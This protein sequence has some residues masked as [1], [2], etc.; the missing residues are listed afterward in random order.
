MATANITQGF[1]AVTPKRDCPHCTEDNIAPKDAFENVN[2]ED[3]CSDCEHKGENWLCL[4]PSCKT[5]RCSRYVKS[6]MVAHNSANSE[7]PICFSFADFSFWCYSCDSYVVHPLL[8]HTEAFYLQK[9]GELSDRE[10]LQQIRDSKHQEQIREEDEDEDENSGAAV[11][12]SA[13]TGEAEEE[14]KNDPVDSLTAAVADLSLEP[15]K[16]FTYQNLVDGLKTNKFKNIMVMTGAGVSVS[17]GIP[18]FRS[19]GTG[20]YDN[21]KEY[22][23]PQPECIFAI[24]FFLNQPEPFYRFAQHFDLTKHNATPTHYFIKMLQDKGVLWKNPTQNID[25]LEEKTGMNMDDVI[26]AHGA[27]RGAHCAKCKKEANYEALQQ[28]IR[29]QVILRCES[30]SSPVKPGIVFFGEA[31][32]SEFGQVMD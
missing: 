14:K 30:C 1:H 16:N 13:G 2:V 11:G 31:L 28:A 23:L 12:A 3:P 21:L 24:D 9:F 29:D 18:D 26:Q 32:P 22:N 4:K 27:N 19:P 6:H 10:V 20:I 17:A 15:E 25:N 8:N 5:V 7:H